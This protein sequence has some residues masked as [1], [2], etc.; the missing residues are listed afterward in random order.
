MDL[1]TSKPH[2]HLRIVLGQNVNYD[3]QTIATLINNQ[4]EIDTLMR[5]IEI[6]KPYLC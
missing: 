6:L 3:D 5:T 4:P 2:D 1:E